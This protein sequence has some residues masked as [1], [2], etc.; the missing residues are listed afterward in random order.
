MLAKAA[1]GSLEREEW[2][3]QL[4]G[5]PAQPPRAWHGSEAG[6][7]GDGSTETGVSPALCSLLL[8]TIIRGGSSQWGTGQNAQLPPG[9]IPTPLCLLIFIQRS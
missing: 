1:G 6:G 3:V 9:T 5:C 7:G 8:G 2:Q 4:Q